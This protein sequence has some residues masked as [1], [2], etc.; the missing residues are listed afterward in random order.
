V[1]FSVEAKR[2]SLAMRSR[3][4][5]SSPMPSL[6]TRPNSFQNVA[7]FSLLLSA[8]SSTIDST[9]LTEPARIASMSFDSCRISRDTFNGRSLESMTPRTKRR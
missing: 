5:W 4:A 7:N 1:S 9:R 2:S 3:L 8:R 6:N